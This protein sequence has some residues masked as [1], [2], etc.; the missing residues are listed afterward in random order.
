[1]ASVEGRGGEGRGAIGLRRR[2]ERRRRS[3][4]GEGIN[5]GIPKGEG[6]GGER[7]RFQ[8]RLRDDPLAFNHYSCARISM[9]GIPCMILST[10]MTPR[11][12]QKV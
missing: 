2:R 7:G 9:Q 10:H 12:L 1:M 8:E 5:W 6:Y 3:V 4:E 11:K